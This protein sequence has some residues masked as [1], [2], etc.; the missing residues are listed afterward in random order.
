M[1]EAVN[2]QRKVRGHGDYERASSTIDSGAESEDV[3]ANQIRLLPAQLPGNRMKITVSPNQFIK[4]QNRGGS[5]EN[6][7]DK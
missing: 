2:K 7:K 3:K 5:Q 4:E 1:H 6:N